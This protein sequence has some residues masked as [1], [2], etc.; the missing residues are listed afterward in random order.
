MTVPVAHLAERIEAER[1]FLHHT[2]GSAEIKSEN[3]NRISNRPE[4]R[5]KCLPNINK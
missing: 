2:E 3:P 4:I 1:G 5:I